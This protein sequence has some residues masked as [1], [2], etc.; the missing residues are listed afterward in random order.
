[1]RLEIR[2]AHCGYRG[3]SVIRGLSLTLEPGEIL[4]LLGPNGSGKTTLFRAVLG[5]LKLE[6]GQIIVGG[7]DTRDMPRGSLARMMGYVPQT[8]SPPFPFRVL[9]VV[10]MGRTARL[11]VF[12]A[13]SNGDIAVS[14]QVLE[15]LNI[16]NLAER[17]YTELSGGERQLVLMARALAQEPRILVMDEPTSSLDLT[18]QVMV[19]SHIRKL[20]MSGLS[21]MMTTHFP[22]H[23]FLCATRVALMHKG[24]LVDTGRPAEV[25]TESNLRSVYGVHA[26][27]VTVRFDGSFAA[28]REDRSESTQVQEATVCVPMMN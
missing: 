26:R 21:I 6:R 16:S 3:K 24:E 15:S 25:I 13:P 4:C 7:R 28:I 27:I 8:H 18:N 23:A 5:L 9:D 1:M 11:G 12:S 17:A 2:N 20:A 22:D 19:L 14:L 10:L